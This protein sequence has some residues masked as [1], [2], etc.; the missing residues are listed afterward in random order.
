MSIKYNIHQD[1]PRKDGQPA[2]CHLRT[3]NLT[4]VDN[5]SLTRAIR[6][7]C[8]A[9]SEGSCIGIL[10]DMADT[11]PELLA[12]GRAVH[13][14]GLGTFAPHV[15]GDVEATAR[16]TRVSNL[17]VGGIDFHPDDQLLLAVNRQAR[18]EHVLETR[19]DLPTDA[20]LDIFLDEHF[21][22]H[23]TLRRHQLES[24]FLLSK[25]RTLHL[26]EHLVAIHRLRPQ[27]TRHT[28]HYVRA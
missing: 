20:E 14:E 18:F 27:G 15:E 11:M 21:A 24:H 13:I 12:K 6:Q 25:R 5:Y 17:H 3:V 9:Y 28:L 19:R 23:T 10:I 4:V 22:T 16:G 2:A 7:R 1:P 26:L 8:N